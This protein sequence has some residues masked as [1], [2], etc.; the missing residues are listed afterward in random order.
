MAIRGW[1]GRQM[2]A[3]DKWAKLSERLGI[4]QCRPSAQ[5]CEAIAKEIGLPEQQVCT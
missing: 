3:W 5:D 1:N 2:M 4:F